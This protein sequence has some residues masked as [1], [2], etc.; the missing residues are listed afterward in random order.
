[1]G[2]IVGGPR[3]NEGFGHGYDKKIEPEAAKT[4][5]SIDCNGNEY[6]Y[7]K[8]KP[9]K[10]G[11]DGNVYFAKA[12]QPMSG[13]TEVVV[14]VA[15]PEGYSELANESK[16]LN[17]L[18]NHPG[19]IKQL[20]FD[21]SESTII[22]EKAEGSLNNQSLI[23]NLSIKDKLSI[24]SEVAA[25]VDTLHK[26]KISHNDLNLKNILLKSGH[27]KLCDFGS[28]LSFSKG[29]VIHKPIT[30]EMQMMIDAGI[31]SPNE[32]LSNLK[33]TKKDAYNTDINDYFKL[34]Y[35]LLT[36]STEDNMIPRNYETVLAEKLKNHPDADKIINLFREFKENGPSERLLEKA[37]NLFTL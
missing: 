25:T 10:S 22:L 9:F 37:I 8:E 2:V 36:G 20:G 3:E 12:T 13:E 1:M 29:N 11:A 6:V 35:N 19:V 33:I 14:K 21:L 7:D 23:K 30:S 32:V 15:K 28:A 16:F 4:L 34:A 5:R 24:L 17:L 26:E 31:L 18:S 27:A